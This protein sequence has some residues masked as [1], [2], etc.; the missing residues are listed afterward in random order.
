ME[1]AGP[2]QSREGDAQE[3]VHDN[4][5]GKQTSFPS[6]WGEQGEKGGRRYIFARVEI[7]DGA[8]NGSS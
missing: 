1:V 8:V 5:S 6:S 7:M 3:G 4:E 2:A